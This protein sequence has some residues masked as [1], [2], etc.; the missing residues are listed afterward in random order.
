MSKVWI[1]ESAFTAMANEASKK[2]P[3][4]T[5]GVLVGYVA[6]DRIPVVMA[7]IGPGENAKHARTRFHPDHDWQ[8]EQLDK[9]YDQ[10]EGQLVYLG[11]W[12]THPNGSPQMSWLDRRTLRSI[13]GHSS[14]QCNAP[15]MLIG[16]GEPSQWRWITHQYQAERFWGLKVLCVELE[17]ATFKTM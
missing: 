9:L 13:A 6:N 4:E 16:G 1:H 12:H 10:S 14:A 11:D 3:L 17:I 5:G 8:C 2:Y 15:L 7:T